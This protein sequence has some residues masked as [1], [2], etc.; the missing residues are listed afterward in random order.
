MTLFASMPA[1]VGAAFERILGRLQQDLGDVMGAAIATL[2]PLSYE[3][4]AFSRVLRVLVKAE[5][6]LPTILYVKVYKVKKDAGVGTMRERVVKDF[7]ATSRIAEAMRG[8]ADLGVLRPVACYSDELTI[9]TEEVRGQTLGAYLDREASWFP[10]QRTRQDLERTLQNIGRW[11]R[12]F[13]AIE[14]R[15]SLASVVTLRD[16][17]AVRLGRLVESG[18]WSLAQRRLV[19][20][21]LDQLGDQVSVDELGEVMVHAD[22]APGNIL[23]SDGRVT[24][25]DLGM[26]KKGAALH[27]ISR[28]HMQL[29]ILRAKPQFRS[30]IVDRLQR[31]LLTGYDPA[32]TP[33]R[34]L[35]RLLSMLHRINHL[36][37]LSLNPESFPGRVISRRVLRRHHSWIAQQ[38]NQ[39]AVAAIVR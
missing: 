14:P 22:L 17:V 7:A 15:S 34:P 31:A 20:D 39:G 18:V 4:R 35:F 28:L 25:I 8:H 11:L 6:Q 10:S 27:D 2:Q 21:H 29:D 36:A 12:A 9:V 26:I 19:L 5:S 16:Y 13:Q 33:D 37:T 30:V 1:D 38:L 23:V 24:V 32:L 3:D